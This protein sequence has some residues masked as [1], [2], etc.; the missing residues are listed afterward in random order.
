MTGSLCTGKN[1]TVYETSFQNGV[2]VTHPNTLNDKRQ[3]CV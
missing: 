3:Q 2:L 1:F